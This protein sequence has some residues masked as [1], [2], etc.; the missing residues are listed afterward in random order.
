MSGAGHEAA[1]KQARQAGD[2]EGKV[3]Y[4]DPDAKVRVLRGR[5]TYESGFVVVHRHGP[6]GGE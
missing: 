5:I 6:E 4:L 3:V 1:A 2:A